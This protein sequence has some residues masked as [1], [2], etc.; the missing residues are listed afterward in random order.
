[1]FSHGIRFFAVLPLCVALSGC[2]SFDLF[3]SRADSSLTTSSVAPK[4]STEAISDEV[5]VRNAVTSADLEKLAGASL[6]WANAST[7]SAGVVASINESRANGAV[8]RSFVTTR[9]A[10]DGI[11]NFMGDTC[12]DTSGEWKLIRFIR[13]N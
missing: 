4:K 6:P 11:A 3:S 2:M 5:T 12:L 7:G 1:M 10:Y 9:H 8:C 13:Q